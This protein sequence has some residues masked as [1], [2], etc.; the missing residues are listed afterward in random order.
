MKARIY[1][2]AIVFAA[3]MLTALADEPKTNTQTGATTSTP[4]NTNEVAVPPTMTATSAPAPAVVRKM[5]LPAVVPLTQTSAVPAQL[6]SPQ[7]PDNDKCHH[8]AADDHIN[9]RT[10]GCRRSGT[11]ERMSLTQ[12]SAVPAQSNITTAPPPESSGIGWKGALAISVA[13]LAVAG[14]LVVFMLRRP[15]KADHA[16]LITRAMSEHKDEHKD[17]GK[18]GGK[19]RGEE[20]G[21]KISAADDLKCPIP[22]VTFGRGSGKFCAHENIQPDLRH[23]LCRWN[24][25]GFG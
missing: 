14:G 17:E 25:G 6:T 4:A 20:R 1:I 5:K 24:G 22:R 13:I 10:R 2:Y 23:R 7:R 3:G 21:Q 18:T 15:G 11:A 12:T 19:A 16:S 8:P 9:V